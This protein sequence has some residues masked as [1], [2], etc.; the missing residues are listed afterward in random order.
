[1]CNLQLQAS[2]LWVLVSIFKI[3]REFG[4]SVLVLV[5]PILFPPQI[6]LY[7]FQGQF[8]L[9]L[10]A[11]VYQS[12]LGCKARSVLH[13]KLFL[14]MFMSI[15]ISPVFLR[16]IFQHCKQ[17]GSRNRFVGP[18]LRPPHYT[19]LGM[20][21]TYSTFSVEHLKTKIY[22]CGGTCI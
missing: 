14:F 2:H 1:M 7:E 20:K 17:F 10:V 6:Q 16:D 9:P 13:T 5:F 18:S 19:D 4:F 22:P 11:V 15:S 12:S 8:F 21:T 3:L